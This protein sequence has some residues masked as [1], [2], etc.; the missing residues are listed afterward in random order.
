MYCNT[1]S[2]IYMHIISFTGTLFKTHVCKHTHTVLYVYYLRVLRVRIIYPV[3]IR[4][5]KHARPTLVRTAVHSH[6][7]RDV[8][9]HFYNVSKFTSQ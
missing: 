1:Q 5:Q 7:H 3:H 9:I 2:H 4:T 6:T 8:I